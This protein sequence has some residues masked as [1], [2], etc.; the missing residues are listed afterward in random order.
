MAFLKSIME[1]NILWNTI[2]ALF[3]PIVIFS[4]S[5]TLINDSEYPLV[6]RIYTFSG[7]EK[8]M[9]YLQPQET[10]IWHEEES[11]SLDQPDRSETPYTVRFFCLQKENISPSGEA[12]KNEERGLFGVWNQVPTGSTVTARGSPLGTRYCS[13]KKK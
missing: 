9:K 13:K 6:A 8:G 10:Y 4:L 11:S 5:V 7:Q 12:H 1:K 2:L 3:F